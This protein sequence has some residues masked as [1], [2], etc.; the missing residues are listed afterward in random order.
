[1]I[2][3]GCDHAGLELKEAI[4]NHLK[5]EYLVNDIKLDY[6]H[7]Y[8]DIA[9]L[10]SKRVIE[11]KDFIGILICGSGVGMSIVANRHKYI[12]A[13]LSHSVEIAKLSREHNDSNILCLG[14]RIILETEQL[15]IV[16]IFLNTKFQGGRHYIRVSKIDS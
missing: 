3:I 16:D 6:E 10:V 13:S 11:N 7:D 2:F 1:M 9:K 12:R 8:T 14:S 15:K 5:D 4:I